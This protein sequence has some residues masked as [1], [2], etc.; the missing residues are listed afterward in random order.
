MKLQTSS[1]V[2]A[3]LQVHKS[4]IR[5]DKQI[6]LYWWRDQQSRRKRNPTL[7]HFILNFLMIFPVSSS[8]LS[9]AGEGV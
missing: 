8:F 3:M 5:L 2:A 7:F 9:A 4:C 1:T 6:S